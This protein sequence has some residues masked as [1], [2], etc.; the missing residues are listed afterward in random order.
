V[1]TLNPESVITEKLFGKIIDSIKLF[2]RDVSGSHMEEVILTE[3]DLQSWT[4]YRLISDL[5]E[6]G[7]GRVGAGEAG[8]HCNIAFL[9]QINGNLSMRPDV[10]LLDKKEYSANSSGE[11][12]RR[13]GYTLWGSSIMI[14][15]KLL[16]A[17]M[18]ASSALESWK[19]D[20]DKLRDLYDS[21]YSYGQAQFFP[22]FLLHCKKQMAEYDS[23]CLKQYASGKG[24]SVIISCP[25]CEPEFNRN[26]MPVQ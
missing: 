22:L 4:F 19:Q 12:H 9:D 10:V 18:Q 25:N 20:L 26:H 16:R 11:L 14:E 6:L 2:C 13:K 3:A 24:V 17:N 7:Q 15:I 1:Q 5:E 21:L 23:Y 8:L